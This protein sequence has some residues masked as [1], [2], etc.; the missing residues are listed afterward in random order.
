MMK[1]F[2]QIN[3][4]TIETLYASGKNH[5]LLFQGKF[6]KTFCLKF[7]KNAEENVFSRFP[8]KQLELYNLV[9]ITIVKTDSTANAS[10]GCSENL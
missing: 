1:S 3:R 8:F 2:Y 7:Q 9:R 10:S 5:F 6:G 4:P